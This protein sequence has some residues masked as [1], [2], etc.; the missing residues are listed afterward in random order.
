[1]S[2]FSSLKNGI[3]SFLFDKTTFV[4]LEN[5]CL[6]NEMST[7]GMIGNKRIRAS[8]EKTSAYDY[9]FYKTN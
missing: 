7:R 1:M 5:V 6:E 3:R 9:D 4:C 8:N 2:S